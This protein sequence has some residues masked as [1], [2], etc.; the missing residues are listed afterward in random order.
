MNPL[1]IWDRSTYLIEIGGST[2]QTMV[3]A[4]SF[5]ERGEVTRNSNYEGWWLA[6]PEQA[7]V[8]QQYLNLSISKSEFGRDVIEMSNWLQCFD[9]TANKPATLR[10]GDFVVKYQRWP[11][12]PHA[13]GCSFGRMVIENMKTKTHREIGLMPLNKKRD[14]SRVM[15][16][17]ACVAHNSVASSN[18]P[19]NAIVL[20]APVLYC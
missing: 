15:S 13:Q 4:Q 19:S 1:Q 3:S 5:T 10:V 2:Y 12:G 7:Q 16:S 18:C 8:I 6:G 11:R 9:P 20:Y 17:R 14:P